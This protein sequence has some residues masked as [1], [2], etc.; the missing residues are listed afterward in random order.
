MTNAPSVDDAREPR[1]ND[2]ESGESGAHPDPLPW[3]SIA[4]PSAWEGPN[5]PWMNALRA[6]PWRAL[7]LVVLFCLTVVGWNEF[8]F[9][10]DD[11]HITFRYISNHLRGYGYTWNPPPFRP[12]EGYS[13]FLWMVLLEGVWRLTGI[14]PP[15]S[16]NWISL[17]LGCGS[18]W[19][20]ALVMWRMRL[21][22]NLSRIRFALVGFVLLGTISNRTFLT[23]MSS[24]LET[25]LFVWLVLAWAASLLWLDHDANP[26]HLWFASV[27]AGACALTRPDGLLFALATVVLGVSCL[28][29]GRPYGR[30]IAALLPL[31]AV[32]LHLVWR[33][34]YYGEWLPNT[35]YAKTTAWWPE[36]G[37]RYLASFVLEYGL[38]AWLA[39]ALTATAVFVRRHG[40]SR[41]ALRVLQRPMTSVV[42]AT[43]AA[44]VAYYTLRMGGD[45]FEYRVY[46][47]LVPL[48]FVALVWFVAVLELRT[49][50]A[51]GVLAACLAASL[52]I[53]WTHHVLTRNVSD[54]S[55]SYMLAQPIADVFPRPIRFYAAW[56]DTLQKWLIGHF[57]GSRQLDH[58]T[59]YTFLAAHFPSRERG[60]QIRGTDRLVLSMDSV[61]VAAWVLPEVA[62]LDEFGLN[63]WVIAR[64]PIDPNRSH[65]RWLAHE[66]RPPAGYLECFRPNVWFSERGL[67][68][69]PRTEPLTDEEIRGCESRFAAALSVK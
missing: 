7:V 66:R 30:W 28:R 48:L 40:L 26:R 5:T 21:P 20:S 11:A 56:F 18:L 8:W 32:P 68:I 46:A 44:Q 41:M 52:P 59:A 22:P 29:H 15:S 69:A 9:L 67:R 43:I 57:V 10:T 60:E 3:T 34:A 53:Q 58:K 24:G 31:A 19:I 42:V 13:N 17:A 64:T 45:H 37:V 49:V 65:E 54:R 2:R 36:S 61:G 23:W 16:A 50:A 1:R 55:E 6:R 63:D 47:H 38:L 35:Y 4:R 33:H 14:A 12:V 27:A 25:A 39:V 62:V 51:V